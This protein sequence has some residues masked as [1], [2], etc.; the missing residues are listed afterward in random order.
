MLDKLRSELLAARDAREILLAS[1]RAETTAILVFVSTAIPGPEKRPPGAQALLDWGLARLQN[2]IAEC[3][4]LVA[5]CD[6]LGPYAVL[7]VGGQTAATKYACIGI[8]NGY[9]A[10]RLL[11]FDVYAASGTRLG[12]A[13]IGEQ[14]RPCLACGEPAFD[15][16]RAKRHSPESL[17]ERVDTLL[18]PF[19]LAAAC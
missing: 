19:D 8:E 9:P 12:R 17:L 15:C 3:H 7:A 6:P 11:D 13:D 5:G 16:I 10:A 1:L 18:K 2:Q 4:L 14:A